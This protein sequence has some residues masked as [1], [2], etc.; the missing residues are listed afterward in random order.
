MASKAVFLDRDG[1][2]IHDP[3]Y[4]RDPMDV[5]LLPGAREAVRRLSRA[6]YRIVIVTNQSGVA[7]GYFTHA[8]MSKVNDCLVAMLAAD[9]QLFK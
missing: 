7:R 6:G 9:N 5:L 4:L 1:T 3:G 8:V 2:I